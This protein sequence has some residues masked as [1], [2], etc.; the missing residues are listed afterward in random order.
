MSNGVT[1][2]SHAAER[3][4]IGVGYVI[5]SRGQSADSYIASCFR[6]NTV[7]L[8]TEQG[9]I[10]P[11]C[12]VAKNA[13]Q[14]LEFPNTV[15]TKGSAV[16]WVCVP[17]QNK[18]VVLDVLHKRDQLNPIQAPGLFKLERK[19]GECTITLAGNGNTGTLNIIAQG[20]D[21]DQG[22]IF[23]KVLNE[24]ELALFDMYVQGMVNFAAEQDLNFTAGNSFNLLVQNANPPNN[25]AILKYLLGTGLTFADEFGNNLLS[26]NGGLYAQVSKNNKVYAMATGANTQ[27]GLLGNA[28]NTVLNDIYNLLDTIVNT[29]QIASASGTYV[30][31]APLAAN[32]TSWL[33]DITQLKAD[34]QNIKAQ[35]FELS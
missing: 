6:N 17:Y 15:I 5:L 26:Q 30:L 3:K 25:Q 24:N 34:L 14:Y 16:I 2:I 13:W 9:E 20:N 22:E 8:L 27:P 10:V 31:C 1:K 32:I 11:N 23:V 18:I 12:I 35:N 33:S 21:V 19:V 7:T 28:T 29:L 4:A